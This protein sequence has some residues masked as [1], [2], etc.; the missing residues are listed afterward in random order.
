MKP[1]SCPWLRK[2]LVL[3]DRRGKPTAIAAGIFSLAL[4]TWGCVIG[5]SCG[6]EKPMGK[7]EFCE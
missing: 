6:V 3:A 5:A 1:S 2:S 4:Q 7:P